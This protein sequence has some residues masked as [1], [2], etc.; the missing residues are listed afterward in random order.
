MPL[1]TRLQKI[2]HKAKGLSQK[3]KTIPARVKAARVHRAIRKAP[4]GFQFV[5]A[6]SIEQLRPDHWDALVDGHSICLSRAFLSCLEQAGPD[7]LKS[8]F[9]LIYQAGKPLAAIACQSIDVD[10]SN[11][12]SNKKARSERVKALRDKG[13]ERLKQR[14]LICGNLLGWGP[15]GVALAKD[16]PAQELWQAVAEALYRIRRA[17]K[18]FGDTDLVMVKDLADSEADEALKPFSYRGFDTEPNMVLH[19]D[20]EWGSFDGYL[21]KMKSDYRSGI[22]K[23]IRDVESAGIVTESLDSAAVSQHAKA[24]HELYH[25]V[26]DQQGFR[27]IT[28]SETWIPTLA[29]KFG[30]NFRTTILRRDE[31]VLGFI[32]TLKDGDGAIGYY[33]GFD[34][35][36]AAKG[37]PLYLRLLYAL[38]EDAIA[39]N[40]RWVSLGRTALEPKAKLGAKPQPLHCLLRHRIPALNLVVQ[41]LLRAAPEPAQAPERNPFKST[42][43][44]S[45][46]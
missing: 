11:I 36:E 33:I 18:L 23:Q 9:A 26:H 17:D 8:H 35:E 32:T 22:K 13:L 24:I 16:H 45:S 38:I 27:L 37:T 5:L 41:A 10:A 44:T 30:L 39:L 15:Q 4:S 40:A 6:D 31:R 3:A 2:A 25:Q 46:K 21:A 7:N 43:R 20:P 14:V 29:K 42:S 28:I 1:R 34:K 19:M 12:P